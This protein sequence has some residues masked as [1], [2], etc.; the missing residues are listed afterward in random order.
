MLAIVIFEILRGVTAPAR[1][2]SDATTRDQCKF[3]GRGIAPSRTA[4]Y[5]FRD[6]AGKFIEKV[7]QGLIARAISSEI[8][9]PYECA[10]DG[11]LTAASA[12]RHKIYNL[13]QI[14]RRLS[15]LKRAVRSTDDPNQIASSKTLP[16]VPLWIAPTPAGRQE[17][18]HRFRQA[19]QRML[20]KIR[21]NR[22]KHCR[23]R[24][25]ETRMVIS[26][27][28]IDAV[29]GKDKMKV[30]RPLYNT[31]YMTDCASDVTIAYGVWA[32]NNDN[33]T[34]VPMIEK[35][36]EASGKMLKT[37]HADSG[38]CSILELKDCKLLHIN[39]YAPV[40]DNTMQE[41]RKTASGES[42]I[43]SRDFTF[44]ETTRELTCP[45][46][47]AMKLVREVQVP[48]A[49]GRRLGELRFEQSVERCSNCPLA[50]RCLGGKAKRRT[51]SRQS[52]QAVLDK[53]KEKM[54]SEVGKRSQRLRGQ[55][56]ERRFADGKKHR[57][58][59]IQNGRGL[60]R[61]KAEVGL[62]VVAQN[63]LTLY[64]LEKRR[65]TGFA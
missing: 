41:G 7:H 17:Q 64:D 61:V 30:V 53:Q 22:T 42:Q 50:T 54:A 10:I 33:G 37:V 36:Q 31:Q 8:I 24:R 52:E 63:T 55:V 46:G 29:I 59:G 21:E 23:Y 11:T 57:G 48:R 2:H 4:W 35:S 32:Q 14:N 6:R 65:A 16:A 5:T 49:D 1:W 47:Y 38:Y 44:D 56:I 43:P 45:G 58:Q 28:D 15:K 25:D 3:L 51:V 40:Q 27:A 18:L 13:K 19:K 20:E 60:A 9:E 12:S 39:L 34:L 62:L 26:P